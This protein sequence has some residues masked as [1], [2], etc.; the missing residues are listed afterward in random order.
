MEYV[1]IRILHSTTTTTTTTTIAV[2][3]TTTTTTTNNNNPSFVW[4][5]FT[6]TQPNSDFKS[7]VIDA[8]LP[9]FLGLKPDSNHPIKQTKG[10]D[11]VG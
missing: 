4:L 7:I 6:M 9:R 2:T 8:W 10:L 3:T 5:Y 1:P 11:H